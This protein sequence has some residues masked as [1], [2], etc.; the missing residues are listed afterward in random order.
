MTTQYGK[1]K[2]FEDDKSLEIH[3]RY[4]FSDIVG[5]TIYILSLTIGLLLFFTAF[6]TFVPTTMSSWVLLIFGSIFLIFGA[7]ALTA[8]LYRPRRGV[9]QI[10]KTKKELV[11][12]DLLKTERIKTNEIKSVS[13][14]LKESRKPKS[15]HSM[16]YLRLLDG[17]KI[18][19][20]LVRSSIPVDLG[21]EVDKD[22][23]LVSRQ[24]RDVIM[25]SVKK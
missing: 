24:L 20:F 9:V 19:C 16:L 15:I 13:Y 4:T 1:Y 3:Y 2:V 7:Y 21:R 11:I 25:N 18:D 14:E 17:K 23:H 5:S 12:R 22:I 8:G 6:K 10:D